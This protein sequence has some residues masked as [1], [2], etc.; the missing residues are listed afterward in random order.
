MV[1][2]SEL[3]QITMERD[4]LLSD[5]VALQGD[6]RQME[7]LAKLRLDQLESIKV[8]FFYSK[9]DRLRIPV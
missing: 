2:E 9:V 5:V 3:L 6:L 1:Y 7:D 8:F 4:A